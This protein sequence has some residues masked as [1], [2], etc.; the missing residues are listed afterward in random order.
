[1]NKISS[2]PPGVL[3]FTSPTLLVKK[4]EKDEKIKKVALRIASIVVNILLIGIAYFIS[5]EI[6]EKVEREIGCQMAQKTRGASE[7]LEE[8]NKK[9]LPPC[10]TD[11]LMNN[12]SQPPL[13][14]ETM[15]TIINHLS[16]FYEEYHSKNADK[17]NIVK[18]YILKLEAIGKINRQ[19]CKKIVDFATVITLDSDEIQNINT[20]F[21]RSE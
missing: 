15:D 6:R 14:K 8:T 13:E 10:S 2:I 16:N 20:L 7:S 1:M 18:E 17:P 9:A 12:P 19:V 3:F 5:I 11:E 4:G 21:S